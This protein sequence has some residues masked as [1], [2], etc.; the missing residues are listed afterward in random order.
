MT[1]RIGSEERVPLTPSFLIAAASAFVN[2]DLTGI[3]KSG[4]RSDV[5]FVNH[6]GRWSHFGGALKRSRW[7]LPEVR[8]AEEL[9]QWAGMHGMLTAD[10]LE[11]DLFLI[12]SAAVG[13]FVRTG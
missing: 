12:W 4:A 10:P 5:A 6:V 9:A 3:V 11:G 2:V 13:R 7:P 1:R 8:D